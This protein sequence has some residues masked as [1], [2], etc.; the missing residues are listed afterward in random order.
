MLLH[1]FTWWNAEYLTLVSCIN[2]YPTL[3]SSSTYSP[4]FLHNSLLLPRASKL[5]F[6]LR[7]MKAGALE[8]GEGSKTSI[9]R[10]G[11]NRGISILD[12]ILRL[13]TIIGTL[14]SA[15]AMG[16]T[17]ETLPFFTQFTQFRAE[18]DDLPTFTW[19]HLLIKLLGVLLCWIVSELY[20]DLLI[21]L[22]TG[23]LW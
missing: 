5:F 20:I 1:R 2:A 22:M 4:R 6:S 23:S 12:F 8:L 21:C 10:G 17:N 11:V 14:G 13:I 18:Y 9:P 3:L 16:T 7:K 19:V 15:I